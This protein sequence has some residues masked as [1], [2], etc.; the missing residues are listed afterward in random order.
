M[1]LKNVLSCCF[2]FQ[3]IHSAQSLEENDS[4][5]TIVKHLEA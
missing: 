2:R 3:R 1:Q 4:S 5:I